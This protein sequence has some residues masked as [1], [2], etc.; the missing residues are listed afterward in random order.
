MT[1]VYCADTSCEFCNDNGVC[2]QKKI[3][4]AWTSVRTVYDGRQEYNRCRMYSKSETAKQIEESLK[5]FL[6]WAR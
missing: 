1:K 3:A 2:T 4:L 5:P 6:P